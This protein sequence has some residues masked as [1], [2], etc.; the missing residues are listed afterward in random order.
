[1][2]EMLVRSLSQEDPLKEEMETSSSILGL[3]SIEFDQRPI[4][5][6]F[7]S[8]TIFLELPGSW[9]QW[10]EAQGGKRSGKPRMKT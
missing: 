1:M 9:T 6:Q 2:Q 7:P 3:A 5:G 8:G 4:Q 10:K